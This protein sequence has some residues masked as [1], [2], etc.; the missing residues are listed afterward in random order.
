MLAARAKSRRG[1]RQDDDR[2]GEPDAELRAAEGDDH[3]EGGVERGHAEHVGAGEQQ[4]ARLGDALGAEDGD[5]DRDQRVDT[6]GQIDEQP[7]AKG[8]EIGAK[9]AGL[10]GRLCSSEEQLWVHGAVA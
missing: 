9:G 4:G 8:P 10:E 5:R 1:D 3:A 2:V 6:R 7:L